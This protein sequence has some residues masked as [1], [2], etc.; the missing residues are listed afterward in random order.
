[1]KRLL[2]LCAVLAFAVRASG[3]TTT[4]DTG[5]GHAQPLIPTAQ[6][7]LPNTLLGVVIEGWHYDAAQKT[8]TLHLVNHSNKTVTAFNISFA[9]K[10]ADGST[11]PWYA[12]GIPHSLQDGG[13]MEDE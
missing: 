11:N 7:N 3:Q 12:D 2:M 8:L 1:M 5:T 9:E 4:Y 6:S 13:R 10:Y